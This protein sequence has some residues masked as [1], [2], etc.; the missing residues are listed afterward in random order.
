MFNGIWLKE[1]KA[2][3]Y[4]WKSLAWLL[5][6]SIALSVVCYMLLTDRELSLLDQAEMLWLISKII[7]SSAMLVIVIDASSIIT[8]EMELMTIEN[9]LVTPLSLA[10]LIAG[11]LMA[12]LTLWGLVYIV[13]I[14]YMMVSSWGSKLL[15]SFLFYTALYGTLA[16]LAFSSMAFAI[17]FFFRSMK[18][19]ISTSIIVVFALGLSALFSAPIKTSAA[20]K[21][22]GVIN[23]VDNIFASLD[24]VLVDFQP[25]LLQNARYIIP[26]LVFCLLSV[27]FLWIAARTFEKQGVIKN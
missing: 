14:P 3:L 19:T 6:V 2:G 26:V 16:T 25:K 27:L 24:N 23:P 17:S 20:A 13:C 12:S 9:L 22:M 15:P 8:S 10:D 4:T 11:K 18:N 5:V 1:I 21:I 7:I